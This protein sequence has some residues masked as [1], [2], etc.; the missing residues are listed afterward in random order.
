M[1]N[2]LKFL[3][4]SFMTSG[5]EISKTMILG[6]LVASVLQTARPSC[7]ICMASLRLLGNGAI[8]NTLN[9]AIVWMGWGIG[10]LWLIAA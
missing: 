7:Q 2:N 9:T 1:L 10:G 8:I 5:R 3:I 4:G 6:G